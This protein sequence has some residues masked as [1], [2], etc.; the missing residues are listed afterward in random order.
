[1]EMCRKR[2]CQNLFEAF[3]VKVI[4]DHLSFIGIEMTKVGVMVHHTDQ[5]NL[6]HQSLIKQIDQGLTIGKLGD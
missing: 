4:L 1:M 3:A 5:F 6:L 2:P